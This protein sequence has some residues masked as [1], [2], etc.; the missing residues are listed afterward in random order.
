MS[1]YVATNAM[2][3][4]LSPVNVSEAQGFA[5]EQAAEFRQNLNDGSMSLR[6]LALLGGVAMIVVAVLG[7][8]GDLVMFRWISVIF[9]IYAFALGILILILESGRR[10]SCFVRLEQNLYK[11]ALFLKYVWGRGLLY[12]FAG[13]LLFSLGDMLD[14]IVGVYVAVVGVLFWLVGRSAA[15]KMSDLRRSAVTPQQ[16]QSH[17]ATADVDGKGSLTMQQFRSLTN[18][19]GMDL[20]R[21]EVETTFAQQFDCGEKERVSYDTILHWW[22]NDAVEKDDFE[23]V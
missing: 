20:T 14:V 21:R 4:A 13:T 18:S 23:F 9:Q 16:L 12:V 1:S 5:K 8:L 11:N 17:F 7:V 10:L 22:N 2:S 15:K 3:G 6:L 19:L